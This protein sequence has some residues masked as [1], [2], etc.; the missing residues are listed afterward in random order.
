MKNKMRRN[1]VLIEGCL[2]RLCFM[3]F[4]DNYSSPEGLA[5]EIIRTHFYD[6]NVPQPIF[7]RAVDIITITLS[8]V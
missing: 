8:K 3:A 5:A 4:S 7:L 6:E 1:V 2:A